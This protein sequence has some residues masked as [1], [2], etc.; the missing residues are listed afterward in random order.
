MIRRA[1]LPDDQ[2]FEESFTLYEDQSLLTKVLL[3]NAAYLGWHPTALYRQHDQSTSSRAQQ[4]GEY[5]RVGTHPARTK[6]LSWVRDYTERAGLL[7]GSLED[8]IVIAEAIQSGDRSGLS[9]Q[10]RARLWGFALVD[11]RK[12]FV[13]RVKRRFSSRSTRF[14]NQASAG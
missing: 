2:A 7:T 5:R 12:R 9:I 11:R 4:F 10:Q 8:A 6:F 3:R 13:R 14:A 1:A